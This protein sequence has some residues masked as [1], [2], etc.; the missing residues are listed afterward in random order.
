MFFIDVD[1]GVFGLIMFD[2]FFLLMLL[3]GKLV[4]SFG[5]IGILVES[6]WL[7]Y[8]LNVLCC[9]L[10]IVFNCVCVVRTVEFVFVI[11]CFIFI[12][13]SSS[14]GVGMEVF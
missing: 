13:V 7:S 10:C 6:F 4:I 2:S 3:N 9:D 11:F 5:I 14:V 12:F 8:I 1:F